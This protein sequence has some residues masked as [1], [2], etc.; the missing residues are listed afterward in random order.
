MN[1]QSIRNI[2]KPHSLDEP[3]S[4]RELRARLRKA[5]VIKIQCLTNRGFKL[6][7]I[8]KEMGYSMAYISLLR[9]EGV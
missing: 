5:K 3:V 7:Q 4:K 2:H 1:L 9:S 8:A 6:K